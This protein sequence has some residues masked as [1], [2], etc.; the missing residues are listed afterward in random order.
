LKGP[1][2]GW[3]KKYLGPPGKKNGGGNPPPLKIIGTLGGTG[4]ILSK[5]NPLSPS[6]MWGPT[7]GD[8]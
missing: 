8:L 4:A 5:K 2:G 7:L 3:E 1:R 6:T